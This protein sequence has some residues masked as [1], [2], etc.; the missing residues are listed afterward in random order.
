MPPFRS[1]CS[2]GTPTTRLPPRCCDTVRRPTPRSP[3]IF[4]ISTIWSPCSS[5]R[6]IGRRR[7]QRVPPLV[8]R[9]IVVSVQAEGEDPGVIA[10]GDRRQQL[11]VAQPRL[12][13]LRAE[14]LEQPPGGL[15]HS[16]VSFAG[17][18]AAIL[19]VPTASRV[20]A[21]WPRSEEHTS[22]LQSQ[23]NLVCRLLL[24]KKKKRKCTE[25]GLVQRA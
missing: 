4:S 19:P 25:I 6:R 7:R 3:S 11:G 13:E 22:E 18:G 2:Q 16:G 14:M 21:R 24:E 23:S 20:R 1:S 12:T 15:G 17:H 9:P 5:G 10:A 8:R